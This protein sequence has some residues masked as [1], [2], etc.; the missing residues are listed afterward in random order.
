MKKGNIIVIWAILIVTKLCVGCIKEDP[1]P[2]N[3]LPE[4]TQEGL[5]TMGF[6][7]DMVNYT[8]FIERTLTIQKPLELNLESKSKT[9]IIT[10]NSITKDNTVKLTISFPYPDSVSTKIEDSTLV[11]SLIQNNQSYNMISFPNSILNITRFDTSNKIVSGTFNLLLK[12]SN[13]TNDTK[14]LSNGRFDLKDI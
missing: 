1:N 8:P 13:D 5:N 2:E 7:M 9:A 14:Q 6:T 11:T 3:S 4:M 12:N 10:F